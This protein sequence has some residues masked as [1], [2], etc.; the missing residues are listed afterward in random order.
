MPRKK[1][2]ELVGWSDYPMTD[3]EVDARRAGRG[4]PW[5]RCT[6]VAYD[7]DK[8]ADV[9][10]DGIGKVNMKIWY[11]LRFPTWVNADPVIS[12]HPFR[13]NRLPMTREGVRCV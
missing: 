9:D 11:V 7:G 5:R 10:V 1:K 2:P 4:T 8:Y 6:I 12:H 3:E 13:K